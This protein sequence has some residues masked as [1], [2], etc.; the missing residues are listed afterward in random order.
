MKTATAI[1]CGLWAVTLFASP[2]FDRGG[3]TFP[4]EKISAERFKPAQP[5]AAN[6]LVNADLSQPLLGTYGKTGR[7]WDTS[8]WIFG[9]ANRKKFDTDSRM[10]TS[11][12]IVTAEDGRKALQLNRPISLE[13]LMGDLSDKFTISF[14]QLVKLPDEKGGSYRLT[15][16]CRN[17]LIGKNRFDQMVLLWFR[18]GSDPRPGRGKETRE[19][20]YSKLLSA[21]EWHPHS[22]EF[23]VPP[24][25]RDLNV[26][27]RADGCGKVQIRNPQLVRL[28]NRNQIPVTVELSPFKLLDNTF[29]LAP[30]LPGVMGFKFRN[31]LP[32]GTLKYGKIRMNLELPA[33]I[34]VDGANCFFG[35]EV[36]RT[37]FSADG[38]KWTRRQF[39]LDGIIPYIRNSTDF[40][41]WNIPDVM[42]SGN[43]APGTVW[44]NCRYY[45]TEDGKILGTPE[46][47]TLKMLPAFR[48]STAPKQFFTG[49]S[50]VYNDLTFQQP[51]LNK[52]IAEFV[53][54]TGTTLMLMDADAEYSAMLR[55]NGVRLIGA[56]TYAIANG[57]RIGVPDAAQRPAYANY[58]DKNGKPVISGSHS[59]TCPAAIYNRTPYYNTFVLPI[60]KKKLA[61]LDGIVPN[62]EPYGTINRGCFC[63]SCRDEFA[64]F[65]GIPAD[66]IKEIWPAK[67]QPGFEYRDQIIRFRAEQHAKL[68]KTLHEDCL[69]TGS[70]K[71]GFCP[72]VGTDQIIVYPNHFY[73]QWEFTPYEYA[74]S[75]KWLNV[76]G[77][78]VWFLADQPYAYTKGANLLT[79]EMARRVIRDYRKAF[80]DPS[81][82]AKLMAMP[83]GSQ[84]DGTALGQPESL[85][86]DQLSSFLA[87][88]DAS[89]LYF[90][91]RGY[92]HRYW[93][94]F[95]D[96][97]TLI[98]ANEDMVMNGKPLSGV[99]AVPQSPFPAPAE[100]IEPK[101]LP[102][103]KKSDLLQIAAFEKDGRILA[104]VGN[105]WEKGDVVFKL[106]VPGLN[107]AKKYSVREKAFDRQFVKTAGQSFTGK[108]LADGILLHAGAMRWVF[109]EIEP[110]TKSSAKAVTAAD[111]L[112]ELERCRKDNQSAAEAEAA[113]DKALHAENDIGELKSQSSGAFS[114]KPVEKNGMTMLEISSGKNSALLNP[115][116]MSLDAWTLDGKAPMASRF[117]TS[118]FWSPGRNGMV[119]DANYRVTGQKISANGLSV[120]AEFTTNVRNYP[121]LAGLKIVKTVRFSPDLKKIEF[122]V[123]L[124][125]T[126]SVAMNEVGYRWFLQPQALDGHP[127]NGIECGGSFLKRPG[128][129]MLLKTNCDPAS[130]KIIR[131][132]FNVKN[133]SVKVSGNEFR[134][135]VKNG[136]ALRGSF[137]PAQAFGGVAV[138]DTAGMTRATFEPFY[139]PVIIPPG[140]K[141]AFSAVFSAE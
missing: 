51:E 32:K 35:K 70:G 3:V 39:S 97:N 41:G 110:E 140:G 14:S 131:R 80:P 102:D 16:D 50:S 83:H 118:A 9:E 54:R 85:V 11:A 66:K 34:S 141:R 27:F 128:T 1:C 36:S 48:K 6:L 74:G 8:T 33:E 95:A 98:A 94:A 135:A 65:A 59:L 78:Y 112:R 28:E 137:S 106:S 122:S 71:I 127:G 107:P 100:N 120:T 138:W 22:L 56:E 129:F 87:G 23:T 47:F 43:A 136:P 62:W 19:Y 17:Q 109:F 134:F 89:V 124:N 121:Q 40:N 73:E 37:E 58:L 69:K 119:A 130:E 26:T 61:T 126:Q 52:R 114:C 139:Q 64:K 93:Q 72:E 5:S 105:F 12:K 111:M 113:R 29:A 2:E 133:D 24:G 53:G 76:W 108:D 75:L 90:F 99:S 46:T 125:N 117:G 25:T 13:K 96:C 67:V 44:N 30:G 104:A 21:P 55:A 82:R 103:V 10:F 81:K 116:G 92:D 38:K 60:L 77:P 18:D 15:L 88:Y 115:R 79:W 132:L 42:I 68:I 49:F 31:N 57:Y 86:M 84:C 123:E 20:I 45:L 91:P 7:G 4:M 63:G 101:F